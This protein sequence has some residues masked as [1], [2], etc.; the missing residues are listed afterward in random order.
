[1]PA[2]RCEVCIV[3]DLRTPRPSWC[4]ARVARL[5]TLRS[6]FGPSRAPTASTSWCSSAP[7]T[8]GPCSSPPYVAHGFQT[9]AD[10]TEVLCQVSGSYA[11]ADEQGFRWDD[12]KFGIAWPLAVTVI[13]D[14]DASWPLLVPVASV[15]LRRWASISGL[16]ERTVNSV[17]TQAESRLIQ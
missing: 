3:R 16:A 12:P 17:P 9:L 13:S 1:M 4:A 6:T 5:S 11:S 7:T 15:A 8:V 14:E 2:A 10:N